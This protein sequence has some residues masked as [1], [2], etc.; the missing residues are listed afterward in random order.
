MYK[1]YNCQLV[2]HYF[3]VLQKPKTLTWNID[4][5]SLDLRRIIALEK[6]VSLLLDQTQK[7]QTRLNPKLLKMGEF[8]PGSMCWLKIASWQIWAQVLVLAV[9]PPCHPETRQNDVTH[10][11]ARKGFV[12]WTRYRLYLI[13][14]LTRLR[15]R[16]G[17]WQRV[18][19][20]WSPL[21]HHLSEA[22]WKE[23]KR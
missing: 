15:C 11:Y 5:T 12:Q 19:H 17:P 20:S 14:C 18:W 1:L 2:A 4:L 22:L 13:S 9:T 21:W 3:T 8:H 7:Q 23:Q 6:C 16:W 10:L